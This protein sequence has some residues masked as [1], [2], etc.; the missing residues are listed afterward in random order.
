RMLEIL[1]G[2][3][4][5]A[6]QI[7][8]EHRTGIARM[9]L[10]LAE[11]L[12]ARQAELNEQQQRLL[13]MS[14]AQAHAAVGQGQ[15]AARLYEEILW[16]QPKDRQLVT[17]LAQV[18][19]QCGSESCLRQALKQW[20]TLESLQRKGSIEWL[21]TRYHLA[22]CSH[23]VGDD[24]AARKLIGVTRVLYPQL[25]SPSLKSRYEGLAA[26]LRPAAE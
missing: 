16:K 8:L 10:E 12:K 22:H 7:S 13:D 23:R 26:E 9:Q 21:T 4:E 14:L 3:T 5:A 15:T 2:L 1:N 25:G 20:Q 17:A 24:E 6:T 18:Y 19:E 11:S